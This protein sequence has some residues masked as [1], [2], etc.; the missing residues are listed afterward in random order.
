MSKQILLLLC[1]SIP[2][3]MINLD[4]NIVA[5]SLTSISH[6]L[7][8][9]FA[10]IEWVISSYTLAFA[11]LLMPAG[12]LADRFGRKRMLVTGLVVF[13]VAS[14]I[15][16]GAP[17]VVILNCARAL[18]G[19]GAALQLSS[20]L[21]ILSHGFHGRERAKAFAFW[22]S[23]I[24]VAMMLGPVAGGLITQFLGW[25][26]AF[27]VNLPIGAAMIALTVYA[28][29]D[30]KDP[31]AENID[32]IGVLTFS[33]FLG[34]LTWALI[35]GNREGWLSHSILYRL[36]GAGVLFA[37][38]LV[39]ESRQARPM[40]DMRYFRRPTY[41]GAN[42]ANVAYAVAFLTML[43]YLP[44]FFQSALGFAPLTAG[45]L[46]LPLAIPLFVVPRIISVYFDHRVTGRTLLAVGLGLVC[47]GLFTTA[48]R[49]SL[50]SY[51]AIF[52]S[53][54]VASIGA[55][56]LNGQIAKVGMTVIP[57][58]RAGMA[59]GVAGTTRFSG[60][61]VGFAALGAILFQRADTSVMRGLPGLVSSDRYDITRAIANGNI[62]SATSLITAH[63]GAASL[64]RESLGFGYEGLLLAAS[65][66]A[67]VTTI[68]CWTLISPTE[69]AP[70]EA[71]AG[72]RPL[73]V[74]I[75]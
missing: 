73:E 3:F 2:S 49:I 50:F 18:Q 63:G 27:Y 41:L 44:F 9:D 38:F 26:W 11:T 51:M 57:V 68:V 13:T 21:A 16:G 25:Q 5:V 15:C 32:V 59:S 42:A 65:I 6:S 22:G 20:A 14:G 72:T 48:M 29:A 45:L 58:E 17:N 30:S 31:H 69:T 54:F 36:G 70:H 53:M 46:M 33:G 56:I 7:H 43:T 74:P 62:A 24:G 23:V 28:V 55:G 10:A 71:V 19:V 47:V 1:V 39:A 66:V 35:A 67:C 12:A 60:V 37:A 52:W 34:L 4:A 40:I 64:A 61:V 8:A 75:D